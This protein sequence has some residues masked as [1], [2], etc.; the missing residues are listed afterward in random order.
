MHRSGK[1][2]IKGD[3][4]AMRVP[5][6]PLTDAERQQ[7]DR[8]FDID[9]YQSYLSTYG[10]MTASNVRL[11][12]RDA[13]RLFDPQGGLSYMRNKLRG[14]PAQH[15][16]KD[17][18]L[19]RTIRLDT[20]FH[21]LKADAFKWCPFEDDAQ[22]GW[23]VNHPFNNLIKYQRYYL[24]SINADR[25]HESSDK[26]AEKPVEKSVEKPPDSPAKPPK[27]SKRPALLEE[28][29]DDDNEEEAQEDEKKEKEKAK[30]KE[31]ERKKE[32][33]KKKQKQ[34]HQHEAPG[35]RDPPDAYKQLLR[36]AARCQPL[37]DYLKR[38]KKFNYM[39]KAHWNCIREWAQT[40]DGV[41]WLDSSGLDPL[42]F[43]LHH[44]KAK[45][46]GGHYSIY[47][48]VFLSGSANSWFGKL[49]SREMRAYIGE[50]AANVSDRHAQWVTTQ[51]FDQSK[52]DP[53]F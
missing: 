24:T 12:V 23:V 13:G 39:G 28:S 17:F 15:H 47:N 25:S 35:L 22:N 44:V 52:Y 38:K 8:E 36:P 7:I 42:S 37:K 16:F 48:C 9:D 32:E 40:Q 26:P 45:G 1:A 2:S 31:K 14:Q 3:P 41:K 20:D 11:C 30:E 18:S 19:G 43:H 5:C 51:V 34:K 46:S 27:T 6:P 29:S 49:D 21:A 4:S 10:N 33:K 53:G 50:D